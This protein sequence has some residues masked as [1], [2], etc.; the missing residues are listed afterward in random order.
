MFFFAQ[1]PVPLSPISWV[2]NL[3]K[4]LIALTPVLLSIIGVIQ[5]RAGKRAEASQIKAQADREDAKIKAEEV[6]EAAKEAKVAADEVRKTLRETTS[7]T[8]SKLDVI[9]S[10]SNSALTS[11]MKNE[12][13][14]AMREVVI[15]HEMQDL[16]EAQ[17]LKPSAA[18]T[19]AIEVA[20]AHILEL[21]KIIKEREDQQ[22]VID[23]KLSPKT[24]PVEV[25]ITN[26]L[27]QPVPIIPAT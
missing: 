18:A 6:K 8:N 12:L 16:R 21:Q 15:L 22:R 13:A 4:V 19:L 3:I 27:E 10:L 2:D 26:K 11:S 17:M 24:E 23:N 9:H 7:E 5:F 20:N 14:A 1:L 25:V